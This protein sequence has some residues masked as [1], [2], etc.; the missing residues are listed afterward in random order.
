MSEC[1]GHAP[2]T[3]IPAAAH[4]DGD[5]RVCVAVRLDAAAVAALAAGSAVE[6]TVTMEP[7]LRVTLIAAREAT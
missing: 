1:L 2:E 5:G 6:V 4:R 7:P 3:E